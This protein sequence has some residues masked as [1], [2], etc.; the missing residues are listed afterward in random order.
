MLLRNEKWYNLSKID[1]DEKNWA[2]A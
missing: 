2:F 1:M